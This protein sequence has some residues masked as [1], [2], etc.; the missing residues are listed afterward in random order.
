LDQSG[1]HHD[2]SSAEDGV[3]G[4]AVAGEGSAVASDLASGALGRRSRATLV[5]PEIAINNSPTRSTPILRNRRSVVSL[6]GLSPAQVRLFALGLWHELTLG[7]Q[8][9]LLVRT[10]PQNES[11]RALSHEYDS[12]A[13][14]QGPNRRR[15]LS[16][17][18]ER[19]PSRRDERRRI[20]STAT[21]RE[22]SRTRTRLNVAQS[23][24]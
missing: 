14:E 5:V 24:V 17:V 12:D 3:E 10:P 6:I 18:D 13:S 19:S 4:T 20:R 8:R 21:S 1:T 7:A 22:A 2:E 23:P 9:V 16:W 11:P 15:T